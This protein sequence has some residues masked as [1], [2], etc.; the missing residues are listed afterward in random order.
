MEV[1]IETIPIAV[2]VQTNLNIELGYTG[3]RFHA[4]SH[5]DLTVLNIF[6]NQHQELENN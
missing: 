5:R 3:A 6:R 2:I 4:C 1:E